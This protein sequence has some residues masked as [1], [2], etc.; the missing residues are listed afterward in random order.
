MASGKR[1]GRSV[2]NVNEIADSMFEKNKF[3]SRTSKTAEQ[4]KKLQ[5]KSRINTLKYRNPLNK[6]TTQKSKSPT[7]PPLSTESSAKSNNIP[8]TELADVDNID[9]NS[10]IEDMNDDLNAISVSPSKFNANSFGNYGDLGDLGDDLGDLG[11]IQ[12]VF[13]SH[14][15]DLDKIKKVAPPTKAAAASS[16]L[17]IHLYASLHCTTIVIIHKHS[18][19]SI[20]GSNGSHSP[21]RSPD[22]SHSTN[23]WFVLSKM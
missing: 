7:P 21:S 11:D 18:N 6:G 22:G 16:I 8:E 13:D 5:S 1:K 19:R 14:R 17:Y 10:F 20:I 15:I 9:F 3:K 23:G 4:L 2:K 12:S